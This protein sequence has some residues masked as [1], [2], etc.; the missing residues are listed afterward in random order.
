MR[1]DA[2]DRGY[3]AAQRPCRD[4]VRVDCLANLADCWKQ[5]TSY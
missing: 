3:A 5:A 4:K 2:P 1:K